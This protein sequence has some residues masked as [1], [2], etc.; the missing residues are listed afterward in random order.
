MIDSL[1]THYYYLTTLLSSL[2]II[3]LYKDGEKKLR[4]NSV[5]YRRTGYPEQISKG[6]LES[7]QKAE[8]EA[9]P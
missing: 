5:G 2:R 8:L 7:H 4:N 1:V 6:S 3:V 9:K